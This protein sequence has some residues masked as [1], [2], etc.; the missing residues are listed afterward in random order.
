MPEV[1]R[2]KPVSWAPFRVLV[3][4]LILPFVWRLCIPGGEFASRGVVWLDI[5]LNLGLIAGLYG[6]RKALMAAAPADE[7]WKVGAPLYWAAMISG[8]GM[9]V[10]RMTSSHGWWTG[11]LA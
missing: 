4:L 9:L 5:I 1:S 2:S 7:R 10:I 11:H 8:F 6:T 3:A